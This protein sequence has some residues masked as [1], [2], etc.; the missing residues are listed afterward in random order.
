MLLYKLPLRKFCE[1]FS[2]SENSR[3]LRAYRLNTIDSNLR[4]GYY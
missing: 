1:D 4:G 3:I 2:T